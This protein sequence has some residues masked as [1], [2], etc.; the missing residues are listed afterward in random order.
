M[1]T[2]KS[3]WKKFTDN[4]QQTLVSIALFTKAQR[5]SKA[6]SSCPR[7]SEIENVENQ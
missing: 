3:E 7:T 1:Y 6:E 4:G 2:E 5:I